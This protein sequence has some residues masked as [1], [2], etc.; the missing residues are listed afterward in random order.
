M[1]EQLLT[2][3]VV[4]IIVMIAWFIPGFFDLNWS[5]FNSERR[6]KLMFKWYLIFANVVSIGIAIYVAVETS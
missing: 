2:G 3:I 1:G 6:N 5:I 4:Y